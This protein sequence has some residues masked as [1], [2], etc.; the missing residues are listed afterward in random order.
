MQRWAPA[1]FP[2]VP[3]TIRVM[4]DH[5]AVVGNPVAHSRSPQIHAEFARQ[6]GQD[7]DNHVTRLTA[8]ATSNVFT[9]S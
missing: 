2:R 7:L 4:T 8:F 1:R 3:C 6:T 9:D 5:Y